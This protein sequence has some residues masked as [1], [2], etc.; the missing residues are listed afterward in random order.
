MVITAAA[1]NAAPHTS[2]AGKTTWVV[3]GHSANASAGEELRAA[4][5]GTLQL[6]IT[7]FRISCSSAID[8]WLADEDGNLLTAEYYFSAT[9]GNYIEVDCSRAPRAL[10][11]NKALEVDASGAGDVGVEVEGFTA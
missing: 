9:G 2:T 5:G 7:R 4:P 6:Y 8:V 1:I 3:R 10:P 11:D